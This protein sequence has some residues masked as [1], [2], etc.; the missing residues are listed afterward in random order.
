MSGCIVCQTPICGC[1][2]PIYQGIA[3]APEFSWQDT[4]ASL[5]RIIGE[6][7]PEGTRP[8]ALKSCEESAFSSDFGLTLPPAVTSGETTGTA[9]EASPTPVDPPA[10]A[11][12]LLSRVGRRRGRVG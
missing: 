5:C 1:P 6:P 8:N 7:V 9:F 11:V 10:R 4:L 2:D 3:P 12:P